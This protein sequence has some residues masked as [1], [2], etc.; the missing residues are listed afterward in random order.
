VTQAEA[1]K[2]RRQCEWTE[3]VDRCLKLSG[4]CGGIISLL[5]LGLASGGVIIGGSRGKPGLMR[6]WWQLRRAATGGLA[7]GLARSL[8]QAGD[9]PRSWCAG[10]LGQRA[11]LAWGQ[12]PKQIGQDGVDGTLSGCGCQK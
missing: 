12:Q 1:E 8:C 5:P 6:R 9:A 2:W 3:G 10:R 11:I 7:R 4:A